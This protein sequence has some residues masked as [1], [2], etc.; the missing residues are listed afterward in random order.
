MSLLPPPATPPGSPI[1]SLLAHFLGQY[2]KTISDRYYKNET[3]YL[4]GYTFINCC[5]HN[6]NLVTF[7]GTFT[8]KSC[9][10]AGGVFQFGPDAIRIIKLFNLTSQKPNLFYP[11]VDSD[12]AVTIE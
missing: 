10:I 7:A 12:Y 6:C 1:P 8:L 11:Q 3:I 9:T 5:F 4:D 2:S